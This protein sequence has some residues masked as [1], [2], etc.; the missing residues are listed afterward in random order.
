[1]TAEERGEGRGDPPTPLS[2]LPILRVSMGLSKIKA[3]RDSHAIPL[4]GT[5]S[6][7]LHVDKAWQ[8]HWAAV[9]CRSLSVLEQDEEPHGG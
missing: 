1:M 8:D 3:P 5:E 7:V 2:P 9:P 6:E 4:E